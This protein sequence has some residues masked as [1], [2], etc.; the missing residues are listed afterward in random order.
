MRKR[1]AIIVFIILDACCVQ[2]FSNL[3]SF[4]S[5]QANFD[6]FHPL[7]EP[8]G[9]SKRGWN[10]IYGKINAIIVFAILNS[11]CVQIFSNQSSFLSK[12]A[13]FDP[14]DP[15]FD[16]WGAPKR[17]WNLRYA[18]INAINVFP[19]LNTWCVQICS[20][21]SSFLSK[22]AIFDLVEFGIWSKLAPE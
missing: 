3:R 19:M 12:Q 16:P 10:L 14:F 4:L 15:L 5:E 1:N 6:R 21:Q 17:G 9:A 18:R 11:C 20:P 8:W 2:I 22:R 13:I 7:F